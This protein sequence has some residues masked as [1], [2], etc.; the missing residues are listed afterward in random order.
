VVGYLSGQEISYIKAETGSFC[1]RKQKGRAKR[2]TDAADVRWIHQGDI[3]EFH[4]KTD[5]PIAQGIVSADRIPHPI[6]FEVKKQCET[7]HVIPSP[8]DPADLSLNNLHPIGETGELTLSWQLLLGGIRLSGGQG[9]VPSIPPLEK[10]KIRFPFHT[11]DFLKENWMTENIGFLEA[12]R[13]ASRRNSF[14]TSDYSSE[15]PRL[16]S[17]GS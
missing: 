14:W 8:E 17:G 2:D 7:L 12:Y 9:A 15:N 13:K 3:E 6:Y 11:E 10:K 5:V 4:E 16:C 1:F